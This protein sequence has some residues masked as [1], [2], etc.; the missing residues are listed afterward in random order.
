MIKKLGILLAIITL[1]SAS[2]VAV[3]PTTTITSSTSAT[4]PTS[5]T[6][7]S[8]GNEPPANTTW[9][10]PGKV[11]ITNYAIGATASYPITIHNGNDVATEFAVKARTPDNISDTTYTLAKDTEIS[12]I[13][14]ADNSPVIAPYSSK[15]VL[16][17]LLVP[18]GTVA[19]DKKWAFWL[20]VKDMTQSGFVQTELCSLWLITMD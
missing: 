1:V 15:E 12:W 14:V 17:T 3:E 2:C 8:P 19:T 16:V 11:T 9:I 13:I 5:S 18:K 6:I 4:L 10:S 7:V 20:S